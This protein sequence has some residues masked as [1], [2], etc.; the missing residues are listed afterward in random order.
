MKGY[1]QLLIA[2]GNGAIPLEPVDAALD[3]V[4]FA[5]GGAV[6]ADAPAWLAAQPGDNR[7]NA[8]TAQVPPHRSSGVALVP[9]HP[10]RT[11]A[12]SAAPSVDGTLLQQGGN[13]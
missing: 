12:G 8:P 4:A 7:P 13:L 2:R 3:P 1:R 11:D 6:E 5:I 10:R 9:T